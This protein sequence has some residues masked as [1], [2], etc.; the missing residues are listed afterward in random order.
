MS[1]NY[2]TDDQQ[3]YDLDKFVEDLDRNSDDGG[4]GH[5]D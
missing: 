3:N 5:F 1:S 4:D 2:D